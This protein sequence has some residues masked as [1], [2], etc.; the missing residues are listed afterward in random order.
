VAEF[1]MRLFG[2]DYLWFWGPL[3][4]D[5]QSDEEA[6][7]VWRLLELEP[8]SQVLDLACGHG[9]IAN[10]LAAPGARVTGLDATPLFLERAREDAAARGVEV[11]YVEG[12]MRAIPWR[13][14]FDAIVSWFTSFGYHEDDELRGILRGVREALRPGGRFLLETV[15]LPVL[16]RQFRDAFVSE[17]DGDLL[18]ERRRFEPRESKMLTDYTAVRGGE[19]RHYGIFVRMF[20]FTEL[21]DWLLAAGFSGVAGYGRDAEPLSEE[22][23]R[24]VV[25]A[26]V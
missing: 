23:R 10:R 16:M 26:R 15:H 6:E 13:D 12:D 11:E 25:V 24:M 3:L 1:D 9:R 17:R 21:R 14:R 7:L 22:H 2:E 5:E 19:V 20:T 18:I 4:G 8:G